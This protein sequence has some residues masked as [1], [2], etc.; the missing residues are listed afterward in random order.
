MTDFGNPPEI[1]RVLP[2]K[3]WRRVANV[4]DRD[5]HIYN[6]VDPWDRRPKD[7]IGYEMFEVSRVR[8]AAGRGDFR[9][10]YHP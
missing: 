6:Q 7:P 8:V 4:W 1:R 9:H 5:Q 2:Q 10:G 3:H